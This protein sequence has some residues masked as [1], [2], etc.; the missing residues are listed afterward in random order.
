MV[1]ASLDTELSPSPSVVQN[2]QDR[3]MSI[4]SLL[5]Y[6]AQLENNHKAFYLQ[7]NSS[8]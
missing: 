4:S 7:K 8:D 2:C 5:I 6:F 1:A 3:H